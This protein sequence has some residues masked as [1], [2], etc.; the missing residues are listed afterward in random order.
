MKDLVIT[1]ISKNYKWSEIKNWARS[2]IDTGYSGDILILAY[3]FEDSQ[4]E[5]IQKLQELDIKNIFI[6]TSDMYGNEIGTNFIW[7]SGMVNIQNAHILIHNV[8]LFHMWQYLKE[9]S[10]PY[11]YVINTDSRDIIFQTNPSD[12]LTKNC[13]KS[14]LVPSEAVAYNS[15]PWNKDNLIKN[16]GTYVYEYMLKDEEACNVGTFACD[17]KLMP[18]LCLTMYLMSIGVGHC[19]QPS[20]NILTRGILQNNCKVV[21]FKDSWALQIGAIINKFN[22]N[23]DILYIKDGIIYCKNNNEPYCI[24]HQYDRVPELS[25]M[26]NKKYE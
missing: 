18:D 25:N 2:L 15:E 8:R 5:Y 20:F 26:I 17:G 16:F 24:V 23:E 4:H 22:S 14:I 13:N 12:W 1:T 10:T 19:D 6:P 7:H 11:R 21:D 9:C 3:N